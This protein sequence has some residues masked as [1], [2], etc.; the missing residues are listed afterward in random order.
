MADVGQ[1]GQKGTFVIFST[2]TIFKNKIKCK[3][4]G[5]GSCNVICGIIL[6]FCL[7]LSGN[8]V[9]YSEKI[10]KFLTWSPRCYMVKTYLSLINLFSNS[11]HWL[12]QL[13]ELSFFLLQNSKYVLPKGL[14]ICCSLPRSH[15]L[16]NG[17]LH[18]SIHSRFYTIW[19]KITAPL[20]LPINQL[21]YAF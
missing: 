7:K 18:F 2:I 16:K 17:W 4:L 13:K 6:F 20:S 19:V 21:C 1:G 14:W 3:Y 8:Y 12:F 9:H 5:K 15:I 10:P 11:P